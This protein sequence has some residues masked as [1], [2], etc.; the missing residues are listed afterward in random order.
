[1]EELLRGWDGESV[2]MRYDRPTDSFIFIAIH[3]RTLGMAVG[4]CRLSSYA[5][6]TDGLRDAL[7]LSRAMTLKWA[8]I[9][10]PFGG[11]QAVLACRPPPTGAVREGLL[12]RF[13]ETVQ[14]LG[15]NYGTGV[16]LGTTSADMDVVGETTRWVFG[17]SPER[18]GAGNPGPWTALGVL[19][20]IRA[21][22]TQVFGTA[23]LGGRRV[24]VQGMGKVG[25]PL[26]HRLA[27]VGA[28]LMVTDAIPQRAEAVARATGAELV[29][30]EDTYRTPCDVLA[31]CAIG[32][33]LN[34]R[35][36]AQ[37][38]CRIVAGSA[39]NQLEADADA[40]RLHDRGILYAPD[41]VINAGGAIA[42]GGL[43]V[44]RWTTEQVEQ[45]VQQIGN[46]L[47]EILADSVR[48]EESPL[49]EANRR[50]ERVIEAT[51]LKGEGAAS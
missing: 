19:S 15:G 36:V 45:R 31:P 3:D 21:A 30:P 26:A 40:D 27:E 41:F 12:R 14:S 32:G 28:V 8:A 35:S 34:E 49:Y 37:L 1:M 22:C 43:E 20:G 13:G 42:L 51:R 39:N 4:G 9:D 16:D 6:P 46:T 33:I 50:A 24:L 44:L 7:R 10:F 5:S 48:A 18:G 2:V 47:A 29:A 17:R 11:G 25:S 23:E 38:Q